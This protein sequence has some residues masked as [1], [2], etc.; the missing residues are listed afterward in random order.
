MN[1]QTQDFDLETIH[2]KGMELFHIT[3]TAY[4]LSPNS[5]MEYKISGD[6]KIR[7]FITNDIEQMNNL[8]LYLHVP[9]CKTR[10]KF[11]EYVVT[12]GEEAEMKDDYVKRLCKEIDMYAE[13]AGNKEI[14]GFDIGGG[15]PTELSEQH[16]STLM[17][18]IHAGFNVKNIEAPSIETTPLNALNDTGKLRH[19]RQL[20]FPR[21]SMG[22]QTSNKALLGKMERDGGDSMYNRA[23]EQI[24]KAGFESLNLD[25]MYGFKEQ[26]SGD[27]LDTVNNALSLAPEHITLYE[28]RYKFTKIA[29]DAK[30]VTKE[31]LNNLYECAYNALTEAGYA[32]NYGKNTFSKVPGDYGTSSYL[33][34]RVIN[35]TPYLGLGAGAQSFGQNYLAY[36][37]G[38]ATKSIKEYMAKIDGGTFPIQDIYDLPL[39]ESMAKATSVMFY[40]GSINFNAFY[41]RFGVHPLKTF[42]K[43]L[44]FLVSNELMEIKGGSAVITK[45]GV[46]HMN[47]VIPMF[48]S[49][50]SKNEMMNMKGLKLPSTNEKPAIETNYRILAE[51][52][53]CVRG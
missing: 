48:Y 49:K 24:R 40:F 32:A 6:G 38:A 28:M 27:F 23:V 53:K 9:F 20:G 22:M 17:E 45:K 15:T 42:R 7:D 47:G 13:L 30:F 10:C 37:S 8:S 3:N 52:L 1:A 31:N 26:S 16:L 39:E 4:P 36:N 2:N 25:L 41:K 34:E 12:S 46:K 14:V 19:I 50:R 18:R 5:L 29:N 43:E 33:T 51:R 44:E 21:I 11:C 35:A